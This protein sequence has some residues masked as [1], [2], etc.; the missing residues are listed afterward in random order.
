MVVI[1]KY[2]GMEFKNY[3]EYKEWCKQGNINTYRLYAQTFNE[4]PSMELSIAM[5]NLADILVNNFGLT[6]DEIEEIELSTL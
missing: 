4:K 1:M 6:Y 5:T 2:M 3:E